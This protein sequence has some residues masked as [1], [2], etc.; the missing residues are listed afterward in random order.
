MKTT[1]PKVYVV[2][3]RPRAA[4]AFLPMAKAIYEAVSN[5]KTTFPTPNP[6][7]AQLST[8]LNAFDAAQTAVLSHTKGA[9]QTRDAAMTV[10]VTCCT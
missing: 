4:A 1:V 9:A 5:A 3:R 2:L 6:P 7:L 8:D 10:V